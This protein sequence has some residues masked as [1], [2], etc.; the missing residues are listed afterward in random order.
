MARVFDAHFTGNGR[1]E[2]PPQPHGFAVIS[3]IL[4]WVVY[5]DALRY[6]PVESMA[7]GGKTQAVWC[8]EILPAG[9]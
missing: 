4:L 1:C 5:W 6:R 8:Y 2:S 3:K 7:S 9:P